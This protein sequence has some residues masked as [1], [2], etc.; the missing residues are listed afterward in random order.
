VFCKKEGKW[1]EVPHVQMF[2][3]LKDHPEWLNKCRLDT[4]TM[5]TLCKNIPNSLESKNPSN[6]PSA[7]LL[8]PDPATS[9]TRR[10]PTGLHPLQLI[11]GGDR[12]HVPFRVSEL[13]EIKKDL[14][15][16]T[17]NPDQYIQAFRE[18]SQNFELSWKDV[19][20]LLSQ[21]LTSLE[22]LWVLE[23]AVTAGDNYHLDKSG[24]K[25]LSHTGPSQE[26]EGEGEERDT[27]YLEGSLDSQFQQ[28]IRQCLGMTLSGILKMT[29]MNGAITISST[30]F[31]RV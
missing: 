22:K 4:Q 20:L 13:K 2:F 6:A 1:T 29:R 3:F 12:A 31:L 10:H 25:G 28:E 24:P 17:E 8:P 21:T 18:V 30:A 23:Q 15:N 9:H 19:M 11:P 7:P 27:G 16:Y 5:V 26:E 14:G